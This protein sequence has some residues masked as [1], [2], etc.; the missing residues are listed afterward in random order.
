MHDLKPKTISIFRK[1]YKESPELIEYR[2]K[3]GNVYEKAQAILIKSVAESVLKNPTAAKQSE[4]LQN[5]TTDACF[6]HE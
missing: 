4:I 5:T 3:C 1:F 2:L 6:H